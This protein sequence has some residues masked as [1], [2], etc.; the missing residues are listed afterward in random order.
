MCIFQDDFHW[1]TSELCKCASRTVSVMEGGYSLNPVLL[2]RS[3]K[4]DANASNPTCDK[5]LISQE[6]DGGLVKAVLA[7]TCALANLNKWVE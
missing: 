7:H 2:G 6:L 4:A 3:R 5:F 1:L